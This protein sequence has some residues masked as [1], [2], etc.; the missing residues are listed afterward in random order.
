MKRTGVERIQAAFAKAQAEG[1]A[2]FMPYQMLGHP[3]LEASP[4]IIQALAAAGADLFE[5]GLPFSDPLADGPVIQ[6]A[7]QR[8]LE[9]GATVERC[10]ALVQELAAAIPHIPFCLMGYI[11]PL[12][13][14]GLARFVADAAAAGADGLIVPDLPPDEPEAEELSALC[15]QHGLATVFLLAP[16]STAERIRLGVARSQGFVYLVSVAGI[17]GARERLPDDLAAFV[18]RARAEA[19]RQAPGRPLYLAVGFGISTPAL[20]AQVA[21]IADGVIVGSALVKLAEQSG[22]DPA[23]AVASFAAELAQ[24]A[25]RSPDGR[26]QAAGLS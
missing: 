18:Q 13:A 25:R 3:T 12:L 14:Y 2:A 17:T 16:T 10:L 6:A 23:Q 1:R 9:N 15:R 11:N 26:G 5:L 22:D 7:G 8:A 24:A 19:Q 21:Q 20:S 4:A